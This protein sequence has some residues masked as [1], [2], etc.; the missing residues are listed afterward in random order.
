[1]HDYP[2]ADL[3]LRS[4]ADPNARTKGGKTPYAMLTPV[5]EW[6]K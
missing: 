4:G 3:L 2:L 5:E 1:L 6:L